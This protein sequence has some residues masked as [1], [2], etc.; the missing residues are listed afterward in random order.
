[1]KNHSVNEEKNPSSL[2]HGSARTAHPT[3]S[4]KTYKWDNA[5]EWLDQYLASLDPAE[6]LQEARN[7][8]RRLG[9]DEIQDLY[10]SDMAAQGYFTAI[11]DEPCDD[12]DGTTTKHD[13]DCPTL[14]TT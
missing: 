6:L 1:M 13:E 12:C 3:S 9:D 7:L 2:D 5:Q 14:E 4:E 8:A 11:G 10:Q